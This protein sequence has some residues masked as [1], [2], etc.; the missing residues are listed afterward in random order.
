[1]VLTLWPETALFQL[2]KHC[3]IPPFNYFSSG[4]VCSYRFPGFYMH[5]CSLIL[6]YTAC[7]CPVFVNFLLRGMGWTGLP[8]GTAP[9]RAAD[10]SEECCNS[11]VGCDGFNAFAMCITIGH[12]TYMCMI[13]QEGNVGSWW[14][15]KFL[16]F[17]YLIL[18]K[19][20]N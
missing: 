19:A 5:F 13:L 11:S 2:E 1:M 6:S 3:H 8:A 18:L 14:R 16:L 9:R 15:E 12:K 20:Q 17:P 7:S 10:I 4:R